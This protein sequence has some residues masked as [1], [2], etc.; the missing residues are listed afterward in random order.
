MANVGTSTA[1]ISVDGSSTQSITSGSSKLINGIN[2][3]VT[4]VASSNAGG[5]TATILVGANQLSFLDGQAVQ[6]GTNNNQIQGTMVSFQ[7]GT[8]SALAKLT[9]AYLHQV[10]IA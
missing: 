4:S 8:I 7:G 6:V 9:I 1:Y 5:N 2:V 3:A 10:H